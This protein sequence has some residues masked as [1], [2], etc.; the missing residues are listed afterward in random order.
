VLLGG[1]PQLWEP[2]DAAIGRLTPRTPELLGILAKT[3]SDPVRLALPA[4]GRLDALIAGLSQE[5]IPARIVRTGIAAAY[6]DIPL[7]AL[8]Q[9]GT[10]ALSIY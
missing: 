3:F 10:A 1:R 2:F 7:I 9:Q 8:V 5:T 6:P 4:L